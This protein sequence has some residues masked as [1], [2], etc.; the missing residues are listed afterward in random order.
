MTTELAARLATHL[1]RSDGQE[2]LCFLL[3]RPSTGATRTT[4]IVAEAIWPGDGE[5]IVRGNVSF[6]SGYFLCAATRAA[7]TGAGLALIHSHPDGLG[8]QGL[9]RDDHAAEAGHAAQTAVHYRAERRWTTRFGR[10]L[11]DLL[12]RLV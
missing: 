4:A 11:D 6:M 10:R 5:R 8:W 3:W 7:Q 1:D 12:W 2:D 9:S